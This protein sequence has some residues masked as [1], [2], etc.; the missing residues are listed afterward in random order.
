M[1]YSN[2]KLQKISGIVEN[3]IFV[4]K[5]NG[6]AVLE[7]VDDNDDLITAV[8]SLSEICVGEEIVLHG[9]FKT[10]VNYGEQFKVEM[11]E[12]SMPSGLTALR[13]YLAAG[14][15]PYIGAAL[16]NKIVDTFQDKTLEIIA[17]DAKKLSEIKG[18]S[19]KKAL[20][21]QDEFKRKY[22]VRETIAYLNSLNISAQDAILLFNT[23][24]EH[25]SEL[26]RNNP[27][28]LCNYP[29][30]SEFEK[31]DNI[32]LSFSIEYNSSKRVHAGILYVL[33]YN[34][35]NNG[36]TCA[37]CEK[38][39][40][41][42]CGFLNVEKN[43]VLSAFE[44][45]Q[46]N[47]EIKTASI[48]NVN[49]AFLNEYY[50]A[51]T[52]IALHIKSLL[53]FP[54]SDISKREQLI[55]KLEAIADIKYA[56]L[57]KK[58]IENALSHKI[59]IL[60]GGPGT[61]KTTTV[62]GIINA[63]DMTGDR[64]SLAAPTGRAAKRLNELTKRK[65]TT[66]HRLLEVDYSKDNVVKFVH[67]ERNPL[68][69]DV[70]IIDEMSMVDVL[71]FNSLL[72][73]LKPTCKII[74]IGDEDQLPSV[75]GGNVL[76]CLLSSH[77][78]PFVRLNEVFRQAAQSDIVSN[79]HKV[80]K[81]QALSSS[82]YES[83]FF[84]LER[85]SA[86]Q[87]SFLVCELVSERL[88]KKYNFNMLEDIQ[89]LCPTKIGPL[90]TIALNAALQDKI[91]PFS[92]NKAQLILQDRIFRVGDK[93]MQI[94][95]NYDLPFTKLNSNEEGTGVFNGDLGI[96]SEID[97]RLNTLTVISEDRQIIYPSEF[98]YELELAY[99]ITIHK[100]QG[101]EFEAIIVPLF[102]VPKRLCYRNL[103]Y[104]GITRAKQLCIM[105]GQMHQA[106]N[107]IDNALKNKRYSCLSDFLI[108]D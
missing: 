59:F 53:K 20:K 42:T 58:A 63:F 10:H 45:L 79:A 37:P 106:Q 6:Y 18:I 11:F 72:C 22:S 40:D 38:I 99:A 92:P 64:V 78:V 80:V 93:V 3:I 95:N 70:V 56:P 46:I 35:Q 85:P 4:K 52:N 34:L 108:Y 1:S 60:T 61:G 107:M 31:A 88:P 8:G 33:R 83:D 24:G 55:E 69:T 44:E 19:F 14:S 100:S 28:V 96:I 21:I 65:A 87:C 90:G 102:D 36:H 91:N 32:A 17:T 89:V 13:K 15:L 77:C 62:N 94:K 50:N 51:E 5:E 101:S 29:T 74:L 30:F 2:E 73:A 39:I 12:V 81:G 54:K 49:Y 9:Y 25:T 57:Q 43:D 98:L 23:Y 48:N 105:C 103:L 71:L 27:Y 75:G 84:M 97:L 47:E 86:E 68:K 104:T 7:I 66:I 67:N 76:G 16:A 26:V 82:G 41:S